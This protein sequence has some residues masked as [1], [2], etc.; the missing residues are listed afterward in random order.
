MKVIL[1]LGTVLALAAI[2]SACEPR[3]DG[4]S[5]DEGQ[6]QE[7]PVQK[8]VFRIED[9][10]GRVIDYGI[11][12]IIREGGLQRASGTSTGKS[13]RRSTLKLRETTERIPLRKGGFFG[14]YTRIEPFPGRSYVDLR[15][16]VK[17]PRMVLPD[18][19]VKTGY[20]LTERKKVSQG[21]LFSLTGYVFDE[22][23][24]LVEGDWVFQY[25][26]EDRL[27]VEQKFTSYIFNA[28]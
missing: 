8:Q 25:W 15:K 26:Y 19:T 27:L 6:A 22:D 1:C 3:G 17:H 4:H 13:H 9:L 14:F 5:A 12:E 18:G 23:Y 20:E 24:E 7:E 16:V 10:T 11:Y 28:E 21:V 2:T